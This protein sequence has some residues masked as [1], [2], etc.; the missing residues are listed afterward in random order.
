MGTCKQ[1][2]NFNSCA[3]LICLADPAELMDDNLADEV[4]K[5]MGG[6]IHK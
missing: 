4:C 1:C 5:S 3:I 2:K 6:F